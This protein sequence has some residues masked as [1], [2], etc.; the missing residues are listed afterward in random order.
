MRRPQNILST[1]RT[2]LA[3]FGEVRPQPAS[4]WRGTI[5]LPFE[6]AE[7]Y[8]VVGPLDITI[9]GYGNPYFLPSLCNL[10]DVQAGY[11]WN[12]L[13]AEAITDWE[14]NWLVIADEGGDAFI[15]DR[16]SSKVLF[17]H[18]GMGVWEP[19]EWFPNLGTMACCLAILGS[20]VRDAGDEF[21]D[22]DFSVKPE[23]KESAITKIAE[24]LGSRSEAEVVVDGAG[25]G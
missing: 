16:N 6:V 22:P 15:H 21:T 13:T 24:V 11:R 14:D 3:E 19:D 18:H 1:A 4:D 5:P 9:P 8:G 23:H 20:V 2:L 12:G 25:W 17:A 10:W 7:F